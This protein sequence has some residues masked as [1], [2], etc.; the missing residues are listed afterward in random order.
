M[1]INT[2]NYDDFKKVISKLNSIIGKD[3]FRDMNI[4]NLEY[5]FEWAIDITDEWRHL[6]SDIEEWLGIL[7]E[8]EEK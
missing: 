2:R 4:D 8:V 7:D 3:S 1:N 5:L 6:D